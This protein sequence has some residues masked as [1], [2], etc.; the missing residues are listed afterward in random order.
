[1]GSAFRFHRLFF[2]VC[3]LCSGTAAFAQ[4]AAG[5]GDHHATDQGDAHEM[6]A[7]E[8]VPAAPPA[9]Y[10]HESLVMWIA[11]SMGVVGVLVL[12][13]G[14]FCFVVTLLVTIRGQ[15][16]F[17]CAALVLL[18]PIPLLI[19]LFGT[20]K[21]LI[22]SFQVLALYPGPV[23]AGELCAAI[24][25]TLVTPMLGLVVMVPSYLVATLGSIFR[26]FAKPSDRSDDQNL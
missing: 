25:E 11:R 12:G 18:I 23:K 9:V 4:K 3:L 21:G 1:M 2:V 13:A 16:P 5:P 14:A 8:A 6:F 24:S 15:G 19:G 26:S 10:R 20:G 17:A 7:E 22:S